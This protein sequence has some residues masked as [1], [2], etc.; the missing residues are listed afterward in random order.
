MAGD[1]FW[2]VLMPLRTRATTDARVYTVTK[3]LRNGTGGLGGGRARFIVYANRRRSLGDPAEF[4]R[5][6][7][8][9]IDDFDAYRSRFRC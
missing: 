2:I 3:I 8:S 5:N 9:S 4:R 7:R 6:A 1:V